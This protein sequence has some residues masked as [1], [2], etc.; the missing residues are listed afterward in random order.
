MS[1]EI[2]LSKWL[3]E[4]VNGLYQNLDHGQ[5]EQIFEAFQKA[6]EKVQAN[7]IAPEFIKHSMGAYRAV[8]VLAQTRAFFK[9]Y[10]DHKVIFFVWVNPIEFPH[11][12][13]KGENDPCY[14]EFK[15]LLLKGEIEEYEPEDKSEPEFRTSGRFRKDKKFFTSLKTEESFAQAQLQLKEVS[16]NEYEIDHISETEYGSD[17]LPILISRLVLEAKKVSV[18]LKATVSKVRDSDYIE[19]VKEALIAS[20]FSVEVDNENETIFNKQ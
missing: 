3:Q 15:S 9:I 11:I 8:D 20:G 14:K 12:S 13:S 16:A 7:P 4:Y 5:N 6:T 17:A 10:S 1:Y 19:S 18:T 2:K